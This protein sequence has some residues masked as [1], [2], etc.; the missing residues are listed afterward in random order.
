MG[1]YKKAIESY[2]ETIAMAASLAASAMLLRGVV[3]D[4][5]P[6]EVRDFIFSGLCLVQS[7]VFSEHTI[8]IDEYEG[9]STNQVFDAVRIYLSSRLQYC[10]DLQRL[11]VSRVDKLKNMTIGMEA[12]EKMVDRFEGTEFKWRLVFNNRSSFSTNSNNKTKVQQFKMRSFELNFHKRHKEKALNKYLPFILQK[13]EEITEQERPIKIY[14]ND[15]ENWLSVDLH[16]PSTFDTLAIDS[17]LKQTVID[18]L[19][20]F[21]KRK[22]YYKRIGKAWKRGY[23]LYG[24]PGTGK[25]S[26]VAAMANYLKFDVY[27]LDLSSL[28]SNEILKTF[29]IG[30]S[31]R[32]ILL[33]EDIDC[34]IKLNR[35]DSKDYGNGRDKITLSGLLN[36]VDGLWSSGGDERIIVLTTN[37]KERL[38]PALTRPGRMDMHIHMGYCGPCGFRVLARNYHSIDDHE[39]F[40]EIEG[41]LKEVKVTP[42]EVAEMLMKNEDGDEVLKGLVEFLKDKKKGAKESQK[43]GEGKKGAKESQKEEGEEKRAEESQKEVK[44]RAG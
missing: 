32:S 2:K 25:S 8:V 23:L 12:G 9:L 38:D 13:A 43:E 40:L 42:A 11:K 30:M 35:R 26:L 18:D 10:A 27:D 19:A 37:Y 5:V 15:W 17:E 29:L 31:N 4:L 28:N 3:N 16:H 44:G 36:F 22:D 39:L 41:L 20:R 6:C 33:I 1:S 7:R 14:M 21:V 24:P 34:M